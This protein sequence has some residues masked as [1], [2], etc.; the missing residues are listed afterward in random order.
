MFVFRDLQVQNDNSLMSAEGEKIVPEQITFSNGYVKI[1][2]SS[3]NSLGDINLNGVPFEIG[4]VIYFTNYFINPTQSPMTPEQWLN[5]DVNGD[6]NGGTVADLVYLLNTIVNAGAG[7]RKISPYAEIVNIVLDRSEGRFELFYNSPVEIGGLALTLQG[8]NKL[9][10]ETDINKIFE[11][12]GLTVKSSVDGEFLRL[13][14]YGENGN[15]LPS[16]LHQIVDIVN[17]SNLE[18]DDIQFSSVDG[19]VLRTQVAEGSENLIPETF[20]LHQNYPNPFNPMTEIRFDLP[21][22]APITLIVY[23]LLGREIQVLVDGI[24]PA[25]RHT[26]VWNGR[27]EAGQAASS[28]IYFYR[29]SSDAHSDQKKMLLLK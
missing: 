26:V 13:L 4:D 7:S 24:L 8:D 28:G 29:L 9:D 10:I 12:S 1:K 22:A 16:G 20:V 21:Q 27:D 18:I 3:P 23:N 2:S 25:G 17:Y 15:A 11:S 5:S 19:H 14:V 6:G